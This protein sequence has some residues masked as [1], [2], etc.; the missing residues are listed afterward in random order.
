ME[1]MTTTGFYGIDKVLDDDGW[2][3]NAGC[4][5]MK[6]F[7]AEPSKEKISLFAKKLREEFIY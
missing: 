5:G 2:Y 6:E 4:Y 7:D 1:R 3:L